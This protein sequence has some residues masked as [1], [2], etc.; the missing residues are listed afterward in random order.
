M[1]KHFFLPACLLLSLSG[2][3]QRAGWVYVAGAD[4]ILVDPHVLRSDLGWFRMNADH[5][6]DSSAR[7]TAEGIHLKVEIKTFSNMID[8]YMNFVVYDALTFGMQ[9]GKI[10]SE[11]IGENLPPGDALRETRFTNAAQFGYDFYLGYRN[12]NWGL[13]AGIRPQWSFASLGDFSSNAT[14]GGFGLMHFSYPLALR[15]EYRPVS[16]FEYRIITYAWSGVLGGEKNSGFRVEIPT[17]P[18]KRF[19]LF[20]ESSSYNYR[21]EYLSTD[22]SPRGKQ[23]VILFGLKSG[24]LF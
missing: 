10:K 6:T 22:Q 12:K 2:W 4:E 14:A 5:I 15:A 8:K 18:G 21:W 9:L 20:F 17:F 19:W 16:H 24:S 13:L 23:Q 7:R 3:A 11:T 1:L